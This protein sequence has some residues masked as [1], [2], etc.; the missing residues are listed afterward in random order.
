MSETD[1]PITDEAIKKYWGNGFAAKHLQPIMV[2]LELELREY[3]R[4]EPLKL[5]ERNGLLRELAEAN[6]ATNAA[7]SYKRTLKT[8]NIKLRREIAKAQDRI[9]ELDGYAD[10]LRSERDEARE[11]L[12]E[13]LSACLGDYEFSGYDTDRW[14]KAA[15]LEESNEPR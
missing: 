2:D 14:R 9:E 3:Q 11:C 13:V 1:T 15:R 7:K 4:T 8:D 12:R 10:R 5:A 6:K